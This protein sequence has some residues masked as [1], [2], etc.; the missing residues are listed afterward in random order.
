M[1]TSESLL[2]VKKILC[3]NYDCDKLIEGFALLKL[4]KIKNPAGSKHRLC[5]NCMHTK[6]G[7]SLRIRCFICDGL[8]MSNAYQKNI[9]WNCYTTK[10]RSYYHNA[11]IK[12][13]KNQKLICLN[14]GKLLLYLANRTKWC[15]QSCLEE[16]H[17][18]NL[19][20][21]KYESGYYRKSR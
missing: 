3:K 13:R 5:W 11:Y 6:G 1:P 15:S 16:G 7:G 8:V 2:Q 18:K 17:W 4:L 10:N 9:C 19:V 20:K 14:C 21:G 12:K